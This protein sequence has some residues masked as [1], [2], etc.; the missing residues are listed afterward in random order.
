MWNS[1]FWKDAIERVIRTVAQTA[2]ATIG[3]TAVIQEVQWDL[4]V[5]ASALSGLLALLMAIAAGATGNPDD[6]SFTEDPE[7]VVA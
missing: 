3:T 2:V 7:E 5:G 6:A 4:V 1:K